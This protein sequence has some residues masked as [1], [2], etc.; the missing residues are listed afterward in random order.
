MEPRIDTRTRQSHGIRVCWQGRQHHPRTSHEHG[1]ARPRYHGENVCSRNARSFTYHG[2]VVGS[3]KVSAV[4]HSWPVKLPMRLFLDFNNL[5]CKPV[6]NIGLTTSKNMLGNKLHP[7]STIGPNMRS[8]LTH[9]YDPSW[10]ESPLSC[11]ATVSDLRGLA[12]VRRA[13][14]SRF[15]QQYVR[16]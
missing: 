1:E 8:T 14:T 2:Q 6:P 4:I 16:L 5:E 11:A 12:W 9:S 3:G 10:L 15:N 13:D 7:K